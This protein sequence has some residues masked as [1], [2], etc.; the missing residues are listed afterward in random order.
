MKNNQKTLIVIA[1]AVVLLGVGAFTI[2]PSLTG[3]APTPTATVAAKVAPKAELGTKA[4]TAKDLP[5]DKTGVPADP[6]APAA[7]TDGSE[8]V[9]PTKPADS[10]G[11]VQPKFDESSKLRDPFAKPSTVSGVSSDATSHTPAPTTPKPAAMQGSSSM[12]TA[13]KGQGKQPWLPPL[14]PNGGSL[15]SAGSSPLPMGGGAGS[16]NG[17]PAFRSGPRYKLKGVVQGAVSLAVL[18]D[19]DG[20]QRMVRLGEQCDADTKVTGISKGRITVQ[21]KGKEKTLVIEEQAG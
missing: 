15:P 11:A 14:S 21:E 9:D 10:K 3:P 5:T 6:K 19:A 2:L 1:L 13:P 18:E 7:P 4:P 17:A 12:P 20:N 16:Q 8:A